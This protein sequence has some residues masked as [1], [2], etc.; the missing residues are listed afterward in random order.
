M[1][2]TFGRLNGMNGRHLESSP[3]DGPIV[4]KFRERD[5]GVRDVGPGTPHQQ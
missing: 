4:R 2:G 3:T 5:D 1:G